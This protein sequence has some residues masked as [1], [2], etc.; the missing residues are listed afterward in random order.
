[1]RVKSTLRDRRHVDPVDYDADVCAVPMPS[2]SEKDIYKLKMAVRLLETIHCGSDV[3]QICTWENMYPSRHF[4]DDVMMLTRYL[5][6]KGYAKAS[7]II[8]NSRSTPSIYLFRTQPIFAFA[9]LARST[10]PPC[11]SCRLRRSSTRGMVSLFWHF[12]KTAPRWPGPQGRSIPRSNHWEGAQIPVHIGASSASSI[13]C[14]CSCSTRF[15]P[16]S[17]PAYGEI[18][19]L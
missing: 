6:M 7:E 14:R 18:A 16:P 13:P 10:G 15:H 5:Q 11:R 9:L 8:T 12:I 4:V 17:P 3:A 19:V 2:F 1:L